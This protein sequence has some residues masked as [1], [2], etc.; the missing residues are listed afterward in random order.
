MKTTTIQMIQGDGVRSP[1]AGRLVRVT[2]VVTGETRKGFFLEDPEGDPEGAASRGICVFESRR[3]PPLGSVVE[4][5]GRVLDYLPHEDERPT[6]QIDMTEFR[7][8]QER[9]PLWTPVWLSAANLAKT[10]AELAQYLNSHEGML[11]GIRKGATLIAPSNPFGDNV[12]VPADMDIPRTL[13]GGVSIQADNPHRWYPSFRFIRYA[14]APIVNVGSKLAESV[15]GP[16]NYRSAAFQIAALGDLEVE[17][18]PVRPEATRL[19]RDE[20]SLRVL[21]L[22]GFNLDR[23]HEDPDKVQDRRRDV[24]DDVGSGRFRA[25]ATAIVR[26]AA[27]PE[28]IALQEIQ[29]DDGAE[30]S[31]RVSAAATYRKL[32][33]EVRKLGGPDYHWADCPPESDSDGGQP[34]GNIRNGFIFDASRVDLSRSSLDRIGDG[35]QEFEGSRKPLVGRFVDRRTGRAIAIINVH[36]A[37]KRHQRGIFAPENPGFDPRLST[38]VRQAERIARVL[39]EFDDNGI[40]YY[41]TGDF[42]DHEFSETL[43]ALLDRGRVNLAERVPVNA[44]Y[45]YN[46]RGISQVLMHGVV[47]SRQ[48]ADPG[49]DYEILHGN[50]L[51]GVKPGELGNKPTDHAYVMA[52]L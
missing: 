27:G 21:T 24:D 16:L 8:S 12:A 48:A 52:R 47:S 15:I 6:T 42:N 19:V 31:E 3:R 30:I 29:D 7:V 18:R 40:D 2:G 13:H 32:I 5:E 4:V 11:V 38:R 10:N 23:R 49:V 20:D 28:I 44:R 36:L 14:R 26:Q 35:S 34:G 39:D 22:N 46:H 41:V 51:I 1:M 17:S 9:A 33:S 43:A 37:S 25:L 45:D 50:E